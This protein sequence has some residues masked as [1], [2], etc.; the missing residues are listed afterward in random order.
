MR[1]FK[2]KLGEDAIRHVN[3]FPNFTQYFK[4]PTMTLDV[5]RPLLFPFCLSDATQDRGF[6]QPRTI[7]T[8]DEL[9][10]MFLEEFSSTRA[11]NEQPS[12]NASHDE[13]VL[14]H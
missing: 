8:W 13:D 3:L 6:S 7:N 5:I 1:R 9:Q 11:L 10:Q 4:S 14:M 2:G 12:L